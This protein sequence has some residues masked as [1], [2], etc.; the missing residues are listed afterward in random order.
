M[1]KSAKRIARNH[2]KEG[3]NVERI[4][5]KTNNREREQ[6]WERE[7]CKKYFCTLYAKIERDTKRQKV[8]TDSRKRRNNSM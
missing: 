5:I 6:F 4:L 7:R 1:K 8:Y 2:E 3:N